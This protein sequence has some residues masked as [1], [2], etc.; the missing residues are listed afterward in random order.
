VIQA[1]PPDEYKS[2]LHR[3]GRTGRAGKPG[4]VVTLVNARRRRKMDDLLKRAEISPSFDHVA[5]GDALLGD[6]AAL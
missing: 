6:L 5:P 4:T 1:D 2:Y 3:A